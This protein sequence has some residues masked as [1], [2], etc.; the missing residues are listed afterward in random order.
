ML[1]AVICPDPSELEALALGSLSEEDRSSLEQH[2]D[3]CPDCG[4]V[5][6]E[7][8]RLYHHTAEARSADGDSEAPPPAL[9]PP[10]AR[11]GRYELGQRLGAGGMGVVFEAHDPE[12]QRRVAI[13]LLHGGARAAL[14]KPRLLREARAMAQLAHP[15]VVAVHDV[16]TVGAQVFI[17]MELVEGTTLSRWLRASQRSREEILKVFVE[18]G[19]GIE[20]A[21]RVG[22]VHRD[23]KPDN[24]LIGSDGRARVTDFGLARP[25]E[26]DDPAL[27]R[28]E[29]WGPRAEMPVGT[30]LTHTAPGALVG[31]PAY[32]APEQIRGGA[33]DERSDQFSYCVALYEALV[34]E[35]PFSGATFDELAGRVVAGRRD[36]L[37]SSVPRWLRAV[38][39]RGLATAPAA[40][41]PSMT[42]LLAD[43]ERDRGRAR[44]VLLGA[45]TMALGAAATVGALYLWT[46]M[47]SRDPDVAPL[48]SASSAPA[49]VTIA[50]DAP[51]LAAERWT[52]ARRE[53]VVAALANRGSI[54]APPAMQAAVALDGWAA[55]WTEAHA[56]ACRAAPNEARRRCLTRRFGDFDALVAALDARSADSAVEAALTAALSLAPAS[57]CDSDAR[58]A[59]EAR[60]APPAA[61]AARV[62]SLLRELA[63]LRTA[64]SLGERHMLTARA[65]ELAAE[66]DA[67]GHRP[68]IA[69]A[70]LV[71]GQLLFALENVD[72]AVTELEVA[73]GSAEA[74]GHDDAR[75]LAA[76]ALVRAEAARMRP[77][78]AERWARVVQGDATRFGDRRIEADLELAQ[79]EL[80]LALGRYARARERVSRA[81]EL[82]REA[83]GSSHLLVASAEVALSEVHILLGEHDAARDVADQALAETTALAGAESLPVA[84]AEAAVGRALLARGEA[85]AAF[86]HLELGRR[87]LVRALD[88]LEGRTPRGRLEL[89]LAAAEE[90][91]GKPE[92]A[93]ARY[94]KTAANE[95]PD[96]FRAVALGR[97]GDALGKEG[98]ARH[99]EALAHLEKLYGKDDVRLVGA[100]R[101]LGRAQARSGSIAAARKTLD[102]A[103]ELVHRHLG[104]APLLGFVH[105]DR[106]FVAR[107]AGEPAVALEELDD[108]STLLSSAYGWDSR[109]AD[110]AVLGRADLAWELGQ[111]EYAERLYGSV[112]DGLAKHLGADHP[113]VKRAD[114]RAGEKKTTIMPAPEGKPFKQLL[115][116]KINEK[117]GEGHIDL[118]P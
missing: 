72:D 90:A 49:G 94:E 5:V 31:T 2:L 25:L 88:A 15:N 14:V 67:I 66:A 91:L 35:R 115:E 9:A 57:D 7:L 43:L 8:A 83:F 114:E 102:R 22:L 74:G 26:L 37:P 93:R 45:G 48:A 40:R 70:R 21:H 71:R 105:E 108:A 39:D 100:L 64:M 38:I 50:C 17:A 97:L 84:Y 24:V 55:G 58:V 118:T 82:R 85:Q 33:A 117:M 32:M 89:D 4:A 12:L 54:N 46:G 62:Q 20:A 112:A 51:N 110:L 19:R 23:L 104:Y 75:A 92:A 27:G 52:P 59:Q 80:D 56:Q 106:A 30:S 109:L 77:E 63:S 81:L 76:L 29:P 16:G 113:D 36:P 107:L 47:T 53:V 87:G 42:A 11:V 101:G 86:D 44:R 116:E 61:D 6:A 68:T 96:A 18:A 69:E 65:A 98:V 79:A 73:A 111:K 10:G 60:I 34:G 28:S 99:E 103:H 78:P 13:K 1:S 3:R 95:S 41:Y